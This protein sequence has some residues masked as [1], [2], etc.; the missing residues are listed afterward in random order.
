LVLK[1]EGQRKE[2][3]NADQN[4]SSHRGEV[5][6]PVWRRSLNDRGA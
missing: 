5:F 4:Q 3:K 1:E 6:L 2:H